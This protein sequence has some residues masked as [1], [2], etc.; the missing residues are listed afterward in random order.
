M[1]GILSRIGSFKCMANGVWGSQLPLFRVAD[2][3]GKEQHMQG[4]NRFMEFCF[5]LT[6]GTDSW[7]DVD[8]LELWMQDTA[9]GRT[10]SRD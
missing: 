4:R 7:L 5:R 8:S 1:H 6:T 10:N 9:A 3:V 2:S